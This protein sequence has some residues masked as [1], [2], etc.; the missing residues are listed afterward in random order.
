MEKQRFIPIPL[1][2]AVRAPDLFDLTRHTVKKP[3]VERLGI[4]ETYGLDSLS[5]KSHAFAHQP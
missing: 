5:F 1:W 3:V 2:I 4:Q